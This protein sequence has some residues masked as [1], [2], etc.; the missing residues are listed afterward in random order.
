MSSS[1]IKNLVACHFK[2]G[3][4]KEGKNNKTHMDATTTTTT[5]IANAYQQRSNQVDIT[6]L[7]KLMS[8][9][10][11]LMSLIILAG[12]F[13]AS[14]LTNNAIKG[15]WFGFCA[16]V[17]MTGREFCVGL[18]NERTKAAKE[19]KEAKERANGSATTSPSQPP[20]PPPP[21]PDADC[22]VIKLSEKS[23]PGASTFLLCFVA[24]YILFPMILYKQ[25]VPSVIVLFVC[26]FVLD[27][28]FNLTKR[29]YDIYP[30]GLA[31]IV[32]GVGCAA[33][34]SYIMTQGSMANLLFFNSMSTTLDVCS[35][36]SKQE[37]VCKTY[38]TAT[39]A[40][41]ASS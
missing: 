10:T 36:P 16:M 12:V 22:G 29:C 13:I 14:F 23:N 38:S 3:Q 30:T 37:F 9:L 28:T 35:V 41:T 27:L 32:G 18:Y 25:F 26:A 4:K 2:E 33:A 5:D 17:V 7:P 19:K 40:A 11:L 15:F 21:E 24:T 34:I 8:V 20:P 6:S 31:N 39:G 1:K